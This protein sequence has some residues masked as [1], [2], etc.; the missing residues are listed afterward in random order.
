MKIS[1]ITAVLNG[2]QTLENTIESIHQQ[3]HKDIEHI[4][5][6]GGSTDGTVEIAARH[7][8]K[9]A[10]FIPG[11]DHG[12]YDGMN[13]GIERAT[14][15]VIGFLNSDDYYSDNSVVD[16]INRVFQDQT[17]DACYADLLYVDGQNTD[18]VIR[19]FQSGEYR[20]GLFERGWIPAHPTFYARKEI[21]KKYGL[22]DSSLKFQADLEHTA[23]V[24]AVHRVKTRY[25]SEIWVCMRTGGA[26]NRSISNILKGNLES[27]RAFKKLGLKVSPVYFATK[28]M[29]RVPQF[30]KLPA[31]KL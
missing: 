19:Y 5:V 8:D 30:F 13:K 27:Y 14:G 4:V 21:Y 1:V 23:R 9:I 11:P 6:D 10:C 26:T 7:S 17:V 22:F 3:N 16:Q 12:I 20:S 28:F 15:D 2:A 31:R 25:V 18:K 29:M 24:M